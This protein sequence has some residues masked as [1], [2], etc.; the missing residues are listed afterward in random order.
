MRVDN[1]GAERTLRRVV[2]AKVAMLLLSSLISFSMSRL[3]LWTAAGLLCA[4]L[5]RVRIAANL[6]V[7]FGA[8]RKS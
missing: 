4:S 8:E 7:G 2:M 1:E 5:A 3:Q 6:R